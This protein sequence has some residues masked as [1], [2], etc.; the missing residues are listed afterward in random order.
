MMTSPERSRVVLKATR[1]TKTKRLARLTLEPLEDRTAPASF[2]GL[3][4][5]LSG[6]SSVAS[7][8]SADGTVVVGVSGTGQGNRGFRWTSAGGMV[9]LGL[10]PGA[11]SSSA[12]GVSGDGNVVVGETLPAIGE[13]QAFR[14]TSVSGMV[15]LGFQPSGARGASFDG[16]VVVG[17]AGTEAVKWTPGTGMVGIGFLPTGTS[18]SAMSI[19]ADG[20]VIVG[21]AAYNP[22]G[23]GA[24]AFRWTSSGG[25]VGLGFAPGSIQSEARAV[26]DNGNFV[27]GVSYVGAITTPFRW[28]DSTGIVPILLPSGIEA[29]NT[30]GMSADGS[31]IVGSMNP[32]G[33]GY[34]AFRWTE[35]DGMR[36]LLDVLTTDF[37]LASQLA[38]WQLTNAS[39]CSADGLVIVGNGINP[40]G[41]SQAFIAR[42]DAPVTRIE[43]FSL[44]GGNSQRS[45]VTVAQASFSAPVYFTADPSSAFQLR[46]QSDNALVP[47]NATVAGNTVTLTFAPGPAVEF[48]SLAD[49]RYTLTVLASQVNNGKLDGNG[50]GTPG[51]DYVLVGTPAN[52]LFRLFG[53]SNGDGT[54]NAVDF[55][56]FR[57]AYIT[58]NSTFDADGDT[59][60]GPN[61]FLAFRLQFLKVI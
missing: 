61:D 19:S 34:R 9:S 20:S 40:G 6:N 59:L 25:M 13:S 50:D 16:T 48:G 7:D 43:S 31:V 36:S 35:A 24:Q 33:G 45:R 51:D 37:G 12:R 26:S 47:L 54:V 21:T 46:R 39:A 58:I 55:L 10:T 30:S 22:G 4:V 17:S 18:S 57:L 38:G 42:L 28:S 44:N 1:P 5:L 11:T 14:W 3:G 49:G 56:A 2:Q 29:A 23:I 27:A 32:T 15:G 60:V 8:V 53:D 52:G 41:I